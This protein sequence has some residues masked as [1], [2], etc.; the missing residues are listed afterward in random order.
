[1]AHA[2]WMV[3]GAG[4][5]A[6]LH[7]RHDGSVFSPAT[8][9]Q[10]ATLWVADVHLG[11]AH[12]Y[13]ALGVPV[14]ERVRDGSDTDTLSRL[15]AALQATGAERLVVLGD[16]VHGVHTGPAVE[17]LFDRLRTAAPGLGHTVLVCGN[18]D[19]RS[20]GLPLPEWQLVP[21][22]QGW[23]QGA[24]CG[25]HAP[26][27]SH[28]RTH[29]PGEIVLHLAG[30]LHP[31]VRLKGPGRDAFRLPCFWHQ[32]AVPGR[33]AC[34]VLPAFGSFTGGHPIQPAR[35]D[36]AWVLADGQVLVVPDAKPVGG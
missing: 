16:L 33:P 1:M 34:L 13:R 28:N 12:Q 35:A 15:C 14:G 25:V 5:D 22:G 17:Q 18:H 24:W 23:R 29:A 30:H 11:K 6:V 4:P 8:A 27:V 20:A 32:T 19:V 2:V 9:D 10:P 26:P 3:P 7:L 36:T 21:D 31:C